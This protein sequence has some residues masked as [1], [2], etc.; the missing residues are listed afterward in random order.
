MHL[1]THRPIS[2]VTY[3]EYTHWIIVL[4]CVIYRKV[5][6]QN[7]L[8]A[9]SSPSLSPSLRLRSHPCQS[10]MLGLKPEE[11]CLPEHTKRNSIW[12]RNQWGIFQKQ[13]EVGWRDGLA[14]FLRNQV[15]F[16]APMWQLTNARSSR[17]RASGAVVW[18]PQA[19]N[20]LVQTHTS[21][22]NNIKESAFIWSC[23]IL[24]FLFSELRTQPRALHLLGKLSTIELNPHPTH[25]TF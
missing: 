11:P 10:P 16:P 3:P 15:Q 12:D 17:A 19:L 1:S 18:A 24:S 6:P 9:M 22:Q 8:P 21:T 2:S 23:I 5:F 20:S 4:F 25:Q 7:S 13:Y 14:V